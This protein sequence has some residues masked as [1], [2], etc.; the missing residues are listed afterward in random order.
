DPIYNNK[1]GVLGEFTFFRQ[2]FIK[3]N[4]IYGF[5][6]TEDVPYGYNVALAGGW[7]K[8]L[9]LGRPYAGINANRYVYTD[10]G[11][12]FQY[13]LRTGVYFNKRR[14]EDAGVLAGVN[15]YSK[16]YRFK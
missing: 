2:E 7:F 14:W 9:D 10:K 6:T 5:G 11:E 4:Y 16:L 13:F 3:T 15:F 8:Q 1:K 12:F